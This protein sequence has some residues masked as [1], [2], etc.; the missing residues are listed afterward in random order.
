MT[1]ELEN[2]PMCELSIHDDSGGNVCLISQLPSKLRCKLFNLLTKSMGEM[3]LVCKSW[4]EMVESWATPEH[5]PEMYSIHMIEKDDNA[6]SIRI[7]VHKSEQACFVH[8]R[9]FAK[10]LQEKSTRFYT[11][12]SACSFDVSY[13]SADFHRL[14]SVISTKS[15]SVCLSRS[16]KPFGHPNYLNAFTILLGTFTR[17]SNLHHWGH[18]VNEENAKMLLDLAQKF[19]L[20]MMSISVD[21]FERDALAMAREFL[22]NLS[23]YVELIKI[24]VYDQSMDL[25]IK[26]RDLNSCDGT[27]SAEWADLMLAM[28]ERRTHSIEMFTYYVDV[29]SWDDLR[30]IAECL[31]ARDQPFLFTTYMHEKP[32]AIIVKGLRKNTIRFSGQWIVSLFSHPPPPHIYVRYD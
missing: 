21:V 23:E 7:A 28:F 17:I 6:M 16:G 29:F 10:Q 18:Y 30:R 8:L 2:L 4:R 27:E 9:S 5:L 1:S 26:K 32:Q 25:A 12:I 13:G 19:S 24:K 20:K 11:G 3:R 22:L 31:M 15:E 14:S